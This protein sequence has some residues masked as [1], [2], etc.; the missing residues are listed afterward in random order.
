MQN[1]IVAKSLQENKIKTEQEP[2]LGVKMQI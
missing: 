1:K 2:N